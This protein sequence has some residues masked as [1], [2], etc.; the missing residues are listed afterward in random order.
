MSLDFVSN[1]EIIQ[2]ARRRVNQGAWDYLVG[3]AESETTLRRNRQAFD[4]I[5][6]RPRILVDVSEI[7]TST[8]FLGHKLR[9]PAI[10]APIGSLQ[11]FDPG[12]AVASTTAATEFGIMHAISS[13]TEPALEVTAAATP[14]PKIFQ[15]YVHGDMQWTKDIV[16][17]AKQ[18]GY[19]ALALTV[20]VAHYSRR[21]RPMLT[22]YQPPTRRVAPDRKHLASLTWET[23]D[24]IRDMTGL[25]F[26][27]KGVQTA[28][29][30]AIAVQHG[31][32]VIWVSNHGGRQIDHGLGSM[33]SLPEIVQAVN[34][35]ARIIVD[36]G[37]QRGSDILKA[38][39]LGADA[40]A[41]GRLQAWGLAAGGKEGVIRMLEILEDE[42]ISAMG[43]TGLTSISK[44]TPK[45]V[46][47]ATPVTPAHEM[48]AWVNMAIDRIH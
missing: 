14:T 17:R 1:E 34:G 45:Y 35:K 42:L 9:I 18:A 43:L 10:L 6:F 38:V 41:L 44:V 48:S 28:E 15:L 5:A 36:G 26:L 13:V 3:G 8:T 46:C 30:A 22:R 20:D 23:M 47:K 39:A 40:V 31:V 19:A 12:A 27:L 7:D 24:I 16:G 4:Q 32:D 25:P 33:E 29:D 2:E 11:V 37:V 21:E